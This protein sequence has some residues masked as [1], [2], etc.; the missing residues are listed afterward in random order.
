MQIPRD[1]PSE[2]RG[3]GWKHYGNHVHEFLD[4]APANKAPLHI[5]ACL[6]NDCNECKWQVLKFLSQDPLFCMNGVGFPRCRFTPLKSE[7]E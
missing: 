4:I 6:E 1:L 5:M 2:E 7:T 3:V